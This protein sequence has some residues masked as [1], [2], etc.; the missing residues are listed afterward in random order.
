MDAKL[1]TILVSIQEKRHRHQVICMENE[2]LQEEPCMAQN[3]NNSLMPHNDKLAADLTRTPMP[4]QHQIRDQNE[5]L[6]Q[7]AKHVKIQ[8]QDH[9]QKDDKISWLL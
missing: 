7:V 1:E 4:D 6:E 5:D 2:R 8:E 9:R 3:E